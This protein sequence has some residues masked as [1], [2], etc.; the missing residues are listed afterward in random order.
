LA[1]LEM[2]TFR[3]I[4]KHFYLYD[5]IVQAVREIREQLLYGHDGIQ[6]VGGDGHC[7]VSDPTAIKA[8]SLAEPI[9]WVVID[10]E[11]IRRPEDWVKVIDT[12]RE[13]FAGT[14]IKEL[15]ERRY[16]RSEHFIRTCREMHIDHSTY[17][18]WREDIIS[19]AALI[20]CQIGL[21]RV[22]GDINSSD[23]PKNL[24]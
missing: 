9:K 3:Y 23:S 2:S 20:C 21:I 24:P 14:P 6:R 13:R 17:Y 10:G 8:I 5:R 1:I 7:Y 16:R 4:E 11:T 15:I 18:D 19:Y 12:T 22:A